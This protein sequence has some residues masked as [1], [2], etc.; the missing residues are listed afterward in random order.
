MMAVVMWAELAV[1]P[2]A[3]RGGYKEKSLWGVGDRPYIHGRGTVI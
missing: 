1:M 3:E 2:T